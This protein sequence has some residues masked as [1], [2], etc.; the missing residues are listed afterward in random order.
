MRRLRNSLFHLFSATHPDL[1]SQQTPARSCCG[2][3]RED[4][5]TQ[6]L[7]GEE[8]PQP[9]L[10]LAH[11]GKGTRTCSAPRS[12]AKDTA[13]FL[14]QGPWGCPQGAA[15]REQPVPWGTAC[16]HIQ[17]TGCRALLSWGHISA[18]AT[19]IPTNTGEKQRQAGISR[20]FPL[21]SAGFPAGI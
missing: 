21:C 16:W 3:S 2:S 8:S 19:R 17:P 15:Q 20:A 14:L 11:S 18:E 4:G 13:E 5:Q 1:R 6:P 7:G 10:L 12:D 9:G